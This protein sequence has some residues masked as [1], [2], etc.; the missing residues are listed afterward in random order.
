MF[1]LNWTILRKLLVGHFL[2][3][4]V[5]IPMKIEDAAGCWE[6]LSSEGGLGVGEVGT[7]GKDPFLTFYL[8]EVDK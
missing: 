5:H 6:V 3:Q 1:L 2:D 8:M 4:F 7:L